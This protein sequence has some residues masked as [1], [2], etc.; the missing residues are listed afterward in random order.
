MVREKLIQVSAVIKYVILT[1]QTEIQTGECCNKVC[2]IVA[3][4][5]QAETETGE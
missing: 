4:T 1:A 2:N 5:R 3:V